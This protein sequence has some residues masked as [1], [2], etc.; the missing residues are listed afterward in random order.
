[1]AAR[2]RRVLHEPVALEFTAGCF[3]E[4]RWR[5]F[6]KLLRAKLVPCA[7]PRCF[8]H[9]AL[10]FEPVCTLADSGGDDPLGGAPWMVVVAV[11]VGAHLISPASLCGPLLSLAAVLWS[12]AIVF[13]L[14]SS[15]SR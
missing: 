5:F 3:P 8:L 12:V 13:V 9:M 15:A 1:M 6:V 2:R 14:V 7:V 11:F 10:L 4:V